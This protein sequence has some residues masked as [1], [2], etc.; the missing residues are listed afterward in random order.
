M[1]KILRS[2]AD[3]VDG[4]LDGYTLSLSFS[5]S[6]SLTLFLSLSFSHTHTT[7]HMHAHILPS[8]VSRA[9]CMCWA[10]VEH[11]NTLFGNCACIYMSAMLCVHTYTYM[12]IYMYIYAYTCMYTHMYIYSTVAKEGIVAQQRLFGFARRATHSHLLDHA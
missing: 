1:Q 9:F 7:E 8:Q 2:Q 5:H 4:V 12:F 10:T 11:N 3:T 6:L